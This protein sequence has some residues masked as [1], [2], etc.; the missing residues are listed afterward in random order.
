MCGDFEQ[1]G[2]GIDYGVY[3]VP[4]TFVIDGNGVIRYKQIGPVTAESLRKEIVPLVRKLRGP[5]AQTSRPKAHRGLRDSDERGIAWAVACVV[6]I[7]GLS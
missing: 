6:Q 7:G 5:E 3:G 4:E 1:Y 2:V